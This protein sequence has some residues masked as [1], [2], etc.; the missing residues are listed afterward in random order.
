MGPSKTVRLKHSGDTFWIR[1]GTSD[2]L[3][4]SQCLTV[5]AKV[6]SR[7]EIPIFLDTDKINPTHI[8]D[9][10]SNIGASVFFYEHR[11]PLAQIYAFE[12]HD[13]NFDLLKINASSKNVRTFRIGIGSKSSL[14][15]F[16]IPKNNNYWEVARSENFESSDAV[17]IMTIQDI[18]DK[19]QISKV[20]I[21][22]ISIEGDEGISLMSIRDWS[23]FEIVC[24]S[25]RTSKNV[26]SLGLVT[27]ALAIRGS[28]YAISLVGSVVWSYP[29]K[30][31]R[32]SIK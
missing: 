11:F 29:T 30:L 2:I 20:D 12:P 23:K 25:I 24:V 27:Q 19:L 17:E 32:K 16:K 10:G 31:L 3:T 21:L 5:E 9:L 13:L 6:L 18:I 1:T 14:A 4:F 7:W 28:Q 15:S 22:K 26:M 8:L